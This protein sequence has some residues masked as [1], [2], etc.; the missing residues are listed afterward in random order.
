LLWYGRAV[1]V[2]IADK[3][4]SAE[5]HARR[6]VILALGSLNSPQLLQRSGI[7]PRDVLRAA[8]VDV[9]HDIAN[10]GR[11]LREHRCAA[12][13]MRLKENLGYNRSLASKFGQAKLGVRYLATRK[14]PLAAP[15]FDIVAFAKTNPELDRVDAQFMM[16][17]WT[18]PTYQT[19]EPIA[20]EQE[21]GISCLAE[22]LRPN[23]EG[24]ITIT[25]AD[26]SAPPIIET[27]YLTTDHDRKV[28]A[29]AVRRMRELFVQSPIADRI[30]HET[31]PGREVQTDDEIIYSALDGGY[32]GYHA[33]GTCAMGPGQ[34]DVVD[35]TLRVRGIDNLR[36]VD[37][38]VMPT[39]VAGNL[40]G[41]MMA[42]AWRA[43]DFILDGR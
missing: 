13:K 22:V 12:V 9:V 10:V 18:I 27:G 7:G 32:S 16:G 41:P 20:I 15:A 24:S 6:E 4:A 37:C 19:G 14:G 33:I 42:M 40:N 23:S 25:N 5:M 39:M 2:I 28:A 3:R 26:P 38:S 17:P 31:F 43:A 36:V 35:G 30:S 34:D 21:P 8:G 11:R 29:N 1:G